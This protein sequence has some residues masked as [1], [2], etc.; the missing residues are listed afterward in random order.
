MVD[1][2]EIRLGTQ[3][4]MVLPRQVREELGAEEGAVYVARVEDGALV[5]EPRERILARLRVHATSGNRS[6]GSWVDE[7]IAERRDAA[8]RESAGG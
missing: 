6:T 1:A 4:R 8:R 3:G 5:L 7:L 2:V